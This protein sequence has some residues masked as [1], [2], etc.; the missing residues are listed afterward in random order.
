MKSTFFAMVMSLVVSGVALAGPLED[1][2]AALDKKQ[3]DK[4]DVILERELKANQPS[5]ESLRLSLQAAEAQG[6]LLTAYKRINVLLKAIDNKDLDMVHRS[7]E[8][9]ERIGDH[10]ALTRYLTYAR[11]VNEKSPKLQTALEYV[12]RRENY[13]P[14][15]KKYVS[16][17]GATQT[18]WDLGAPMM[19][20]LIDAGDPTRLLE[21]G[22]FLIQTFPKPENVH[23]VHGQLRNAA[24]QYLFGREPKD[25]YYRPLLVMVK[26]TPLG[27]D[28]IDH[29]VGQND[30]AMAVEQRVDLC[31][32]FAKRSTVPVGWN[33]LSRIQQARDLTDLDARLAV[34]REYLSIEPVYLQAENPATYEAYLRVMLETP[35]VFNLP[36]KALLTPAEAAKKLEALKKKFGPEQIGRCMSV[37]QNISQHWY[38]ADPAARAAFIR[39]NISWVGP[40]QVSDLLGLLEP[41]DYEPTMAEVA[42]GR[43]FRDMVDIRSYTMNY[44]GATKNKA[45]LTSVARDHMMMSPAD[46][47]RDWIQSHVMGVAEEVMTMDEKLALL[48]EVI[49]KSGVSPSMRAL[50]AELVKAAEWAENPRFV[51]L[52]ETIKANPVGSEILPSTIVVLSNIQQNAQN[53]PKEVEEAVN[54]FFAEYKGAFPGGEDDA[55]DLAGV[56]VARIQAWHWRHVHQ[57]RPAVARLF[58]QWG[59]KLQPGSIF[60]GLAQTMAQWHWW[61]EMYPLAKAYVSATTKANVP[62]DPSV[63]WWLSSAQQP[64]DEVTPLF[65]SVYGRMPANAVFNY[66]Y[67]QRSQFDRNRQVL[68]DECAKLMAMPGQ[69]V[70]EINA[71]QNWTSQMWHWSGQP[72]FKL[73]AATIEAMWKSYLKIQADTGRIDPNVEMHIYGLYVRC[74]HEK[75]AAAHL[76]T[77]LA[78]I[79]QRTLLQQI[80]AINMIFRHQSFP[81]EPRATTQPDGP[82]VEV[83]TA[84]YRRD[85]VFN[86]LLP[87]YKQ[88]PPDDY[89]KVSVVNNFYEPINALLGYT[90]YPAL[91]AKAVEAARFIVTV[92]AG[93]ARSE[94]APSYWFTIMGALCMEAI[95]KEDWNALNRLTEQYAALV[96]NEGNWDN[97]LANYVTPLIKAMEE[98]K[99]HE[100]IFMFMVSLEQ[101]SNP[102]ANAA[103]QLVM[104]KSKAST[105]IP[106]MIAVPPGDPTYDLHMAAQSLT[107]GNEIRAWELTEPKLRMMPEVWETLDPSYVSWVIGKMRNAKLYQPAL[108]FCFKVLLREKDLTPDIAASV[109]LIKG[110]VYRDME[111]YQA[112]R[113]EYE[114]LRSNQLYSK[115][116]AG[117]KGLYRLIELHILTKN[118]IGAQQMLERLIDSE[119]LEMQAEAYYLL[120]KMEYERG[121]YM[122][123]RTYVRE[124]KDRI[125]NHV[126]ATLLEWRSG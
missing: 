84:G 3:Y 88:L 120:A 97:L 43:G 81:V 106:E 96:M 69:T 32:K 11:A 31:I 62:G 44:A 7:A 16:L 60:Y 104:L 102:P 121:D 1:A 71:L 2:Q 72:N 17:F 78:A 30:Q 100:S 70:T 87:M 94:V 80:D 101:R 24:D 73:P 109:L 74:G 49:A 20:R 90:T 28:H 79:K 92:M 36:D 4:V 99:A 47:R 21:L 51:K 114:G 26:G 65:T 5:V 55:K 89:N 23:V 98:K 86:V 110:D 15:Y 13:I 10:M 52:Q 14:E 85:M 91:Q 64:R 22:D 37:F 107:L 115:T 42:K 19:N 76:Q 6:N 125:L 38:G 83:V 123:A 57:N 58:V 63:W 12:L 25:R 116:P 119:T 93:G 61:G 54:K 68:L 18:A 122:Q 112:A 8:I 67:S 95:D 118:Y 34:G 50:A 66:F 75:E 56:Q 40:Q 126:E 9:A 27:M 82:E 113:L 117:S 59:E 41:K 111:N 45:L 46:W 77:Y 105:Y 53:P 39:A 108:D 103:K 124:A 33:V 29:V 48:E 35:Q